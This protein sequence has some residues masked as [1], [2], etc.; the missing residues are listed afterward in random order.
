[1][2]K[3]TMRVVCGSGFGARF[4]WTLMLTLGLSG[5][6]SLYAQYGRSVTTVQYNNARTGWNQDE[7]ALTTA[8]VNPSTFGK[9]W[10]VTLDGNIYGA[11][12]YVS[13]VVIRG[14]A[15]KV[16]YVA[17]ENNMIYALDADTG[18]QLWDNPYFLGAPAQRSQLR[19]GNI[20]PNIG[21]SSTPVIDLET[22]TLYAVG[23]TRATS[24]IT[25]RMAAVDIATGA[26]LPGWPVTIR[27]NTTPTIDPTVTSQRGALL[28]ANGV[29]YAGFGGYYG[30]CGTY[31]GWVVGLDKT[32]PNAP[33]LYYRTPGTGLHRGSG[34]WAAG[35]LAADEYGYV[36]ASTGN[37]FSAPLSGV[38]YS[39]AVLRLDP[40]LSFSEDPSDYFMPTDWRFLN[41]TDRDLGSSTPL[42][43]PS[44]DGST[45]PNMV[46]IMGKAGVGHLLNRDSLGGVGGEVFKSTAYGSAF[47]TPA[48]Y[49]DETIGPVVFL[50]GRGTQS[51]CGISGGVAALGLYVDEAGNSY[52]DPLY[53]VPGQTS[54]SP[55]V[56][57][58]PGQSGILW[59]A[60]S[61]GTLAAYNAA[62]GDLL[63][64][65]SGG[66]ALGATRALL[67]F[68]VVDGK[69]FIANV[70]N[71]L[72]S[73][74]LR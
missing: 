7:T 9:K 19:C 62:T 73:Y 34:I 29:V 55:V 10:S 36:Y 27:P 50:A 40:T 69:V 47:S 25:Y 42:L 52:Y 63:Y 46:F 51:R 24:P 8:N 15:R 12:L 43:I 64:T 6:G 66:D 49:Q 37:S 2:T 35:G 31:H 68:T 16:V 57:S 14:Q 71:A 39:N 3:Y 70:A 67:H 1:M 54:L 41:S 72:V 65:T 60:A 33:Q 28:L 59:V 23:L 45:T 17:T 22:G 13:G 26:S 30:D 5:I 74:G 20:Q 53:C 11:P 44:Q 32:D 18:A 4:L 61:A 48:Y 58:G 21:I 38:D 56:T